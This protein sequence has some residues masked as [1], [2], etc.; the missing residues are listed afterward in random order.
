MLYLYYWDGKLKDAPHKFPE[1]AEIVREN[2]NWTHKI[3]GTN[4]YSSTTERLKR[5]LQKNTK[6]NVDFHV[7]TNCLHLAES[8][9]YVFVYNEEHV[10]WVFV[11]DKSI[12][13]KGLNKHGKA[14]N[15]HSAQQ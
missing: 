15:A 2:N 1:S 3:D 10:T 6:T 7:L 14:H 12:L 13:R 8:Y 9:K 5:L 11:E 4:G